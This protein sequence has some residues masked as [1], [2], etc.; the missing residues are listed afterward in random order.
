M[1]S[2]L[3]RFTFFILSLSLRKTSSSLILAVFFAGIIQVANASTCPGEY[4]LAT[5]SNIMG[6]QCMDHVR[7]ER[8]KLD[9]LGDVWL[10]SMTNYAD[11]G[12][13]S[14]HLN[15]HDNSK[16]TWYQGVKGR[17]YAVE[18]DMIAACSKKIWCSK[19]HSAWASCWKTAWAWK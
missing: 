11:K 14:S 18:S 9:D 4:K 12:E 1:K 19:L 13:S 15:M 17:A 2:Q 7:V 16:P 5:D 6:L 8:D 3:F 10:I